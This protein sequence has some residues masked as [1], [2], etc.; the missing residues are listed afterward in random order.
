MSGVAAGLALA[1][2]ASLALNVSYLLQHAGATRAPEV[3]ALRP[4][5]SLR[6]LFISPRWLGGAAL[7]L[8]GWGV[9]VLALASAPLSL[10]QAFLSGGLILVVPLAVVL[11]GHRLRP[12]ELWAIGGLAVSL[13][14]LSVGTGEGSGSIDSS[15]LGVYLAVATVGAAALAFL[16]GRGGPGVALGLAAGTLFGAADVAVKALTLVAQTGGAD[17]ILRSPWLLAAAVDSV[18]AFFCFQRALQLGRALTVIALMTAATNLIAILGGLLVLG[19]PLGSSRALSA[20]HVAAFLGVGVTCWLL[21]PS[22]T[23]LATGE[24][25]AAASRRLAPRG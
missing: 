16:P 5:A 2:I 10:V 24:A 9:Y 3:S 7:G 17:A 11:L 13:A 18:G 8:A 12:S 4:L 15:G 14:L 25:E 23:V 22:Q 19:D 1:V 6:G 20:M 21:A